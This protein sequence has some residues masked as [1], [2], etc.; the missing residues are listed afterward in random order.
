M[1]KDAS[2]SNT[3]V[4]RVNDTNMQ[5]DTSEASWCKG[6]KLVLMQIRNLVLQNYA[7]SWEMQNK[8]KF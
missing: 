6:K 8:M 5:Y 1:K 3:K 4:N 2:K 7:Y